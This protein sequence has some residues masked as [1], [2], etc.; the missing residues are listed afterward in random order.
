MFHAIMIIASCEPVYTQTVD[1][2]VDNV[3]EE[4]GFF[5]GAEIRAVQIS[6]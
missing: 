3:C 6:K 4:R 1:Q 2:S 5:V